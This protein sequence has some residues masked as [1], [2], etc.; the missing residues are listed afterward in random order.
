M[1][2]YHDH[3]KIVLSCSAEGEE[4]LTFVDRQRCSTTFPL[5]TL[6]RRGWTLALHERLHYALRL[7][8]CL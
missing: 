4:L 3:T 1:N 7:L 6:A 2:F 8:H 5:G